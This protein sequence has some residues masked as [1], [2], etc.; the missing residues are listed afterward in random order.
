MKEIIGEMQNRLKEAEGNHEQ[1]INKLQ[2]DEIEYAKLKLESE[3]SKI[4]IDDLKN[5]LSRTKGFKEE[6]ERRKRRATMENKILEEQI[7]MAQMQLDK[8]KANEKLYQQVLQ[9]NQTLKKNII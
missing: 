4:Q 2:S 5:D 9:E 6:D 1:L 8:A 3:N 7:A